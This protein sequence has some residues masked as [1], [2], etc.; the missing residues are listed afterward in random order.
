MFD[1]GQSDGPLPRQQ[2]KMIGLV[3]I[4]V[5]S[6]TPPSLI[7]ETFGPS[8]IHVPKAP[9]LGLLLI[10]P[11]YTEYNKRIAEGNAKLD[12]LVAAGRMDDK[13]YG[14]QKRDAIDFVELGLSERIDAFKQEQV[15]KRMWSV[16]EDELVFSKWLNFLDTFVS[17]DFE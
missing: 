11:H 12:E 14:E 15:Y 7:P 8:R 4:A 1:S 17:N 9:G 10:S 16:E 5:R 3:M 13:A 6:A 2:R